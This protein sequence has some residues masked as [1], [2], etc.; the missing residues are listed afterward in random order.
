LQKSHTVG[1]L[2]AVIVSLPNR[3]R[4]PLICKPF[5]EADVS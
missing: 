3:P 2:L 5:L 4:A 1:S